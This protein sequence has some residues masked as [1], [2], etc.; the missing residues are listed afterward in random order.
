MESVSSE[1]QTCGSVP[2]RQSTYYKGSSGHHCVVVGCQNNQRKRNR[3][4]RDVC[5]K[6]DAFRESCRCG[7]YKLH[8]FPRNA[9]L[10]RQWIAAVNRKDYNPSAHARVCSEHFVDRKPSLRNPV[11]MLHL[12]YVKKVVLGRRPLVRHAVSPVRQP[13]PCVAAHVQPSSD[14]SKQDEAESVEEIIY[15]PDSGKP[16]AV[17]HISI[18][19]AP[20][21]VGP[22]KK[23]LM[24]KDSHVQ[25][26]QTC[27]ACGPWPV[28]HDQGHV[29]FHGTEVRIEDGK[30]VLHPA[31][32]ILPPTD[33]QRDASRHQPP[34][35][36]VNN[37]AHK[38][39]CA[40]VESGSTEENHVCLMTEVCDSCNAHGC[41]CKCIIYNTDSPPPILEHSKD[42]TS[43]LCKREYGST[44][45]ELTDCTSVR[46]RHSVDGKI[47]L[48]NPEPTLCL[49]H[50]DVDTQTQ[51]LRKSLDTVCRTRNAFTQVICPRTRTVM[52]QAGEQAPQVFRDNATQWERPY[53]HV[54]MEHSYADIKWL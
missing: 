46:S 37:K 15:M 40:A 9:E 22:R 52:C 39:S 4:L 54:H 29:P 45:G 13:S 7:I 25:T 27:Q 12:G 49:G 28:L 34:A 6:H 26:R 33:L 41:K 51:P 5:E 43:A 11:P 30:L 42:W 50:R 44:G 1:N 16:S 31:I 36:S 53:E 32:A 38:Q 19:E 35:D 17:F 47:T 20:A 23:Q 2:I 14:S 8:R 3:L 21:A 18:Q 48:R 24:V 10:R